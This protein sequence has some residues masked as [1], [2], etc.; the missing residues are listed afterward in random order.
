MW[1]LSN[2][3]IEGD[4][5]TVFYAASDDELPAILFKVNNHYECVYVH[6]RGRPASLTSGY[7]RLPHASTRYYHIRAKSI[8]RNI[9]EVVLPRPRTGVVALYDLQSDTF[10][11]ELHL[12]EPTTDFEHIV[13]DIVDNILRIH[14]PDKVYGDCYVTYHSTST[15]PSKPTIVTSFPI[16]KSGTYNVEI[17][18]PGLYNIYVRDKSGNLLGPHAAYY[19][20]TFDKKIVLSSL[21]QVSGVVVGTVKSNY[22]PVVVFRWMGE[23]DRYVYLTTLFEGQDYFVDEDPFFGQNIYACGYTKEG[24]AFLV[25]SAS[26]VFYPCE[27]LTAPFLSVARLS[28]E[29]LYMEVTRIIEHVIVRDGLRTARVTVYPNPDASGSYTVLDDSTDYPLSH[30]GDVLVDRKYVFVINRSG[31]SIYVAPN[32]VSGED[33]ISTGIEIPNNTYKILEIET[34]PM[35]FRLSSSP[36]A[37]GKVIIWEVG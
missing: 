10:V 27:Y 26:L 30:Y 4:K 31:T 13:V 35:L 16:V 1:I 29:D 28:E 6:G 3:Y 8:D 11:H 7:V 17:T 32:T 34:L 21:R 23:L 12:S 5:A 14:I 24:E 19:D 22:Y 20:P 15:P 25:S 36:S 18:E 9:Y 33:I 2:S 37:G